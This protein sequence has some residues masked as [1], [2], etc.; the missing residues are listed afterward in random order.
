VCKDYQDIFH[1]PGED[2]SCTSAVKH[3]INV[4]PG[5][6]PINTKP[7]RLPEAQKAEIEKQ[8]LSWLKRG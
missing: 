3:S 6:N 1:L 4:I 2:L 8:K 7:Y 5:M